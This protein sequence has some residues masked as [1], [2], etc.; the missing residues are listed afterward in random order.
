MQ[1]IEVNK[2]VILKML[3]FGMVRVGRYAMFC[4][5]HLGHV[6]PQDWTC[7]KRGC[8]DGVNADSSLARRLEREI[9]YSD[10]S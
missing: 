4:D 9:N 8:V 3:S 7:L 2:W 10:K 1:P 5:A 6:I